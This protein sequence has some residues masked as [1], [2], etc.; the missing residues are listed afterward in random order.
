V[1]IKILFVLLILCTAALIAVGIGILL[2]VRR[3]LGQERAQGRA[4]G[5]PDERPA[6]AEKKKEDDETS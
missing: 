4:A 2:R 1:V 3:H 6:L 5:E